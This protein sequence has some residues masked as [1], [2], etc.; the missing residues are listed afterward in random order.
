MYQVIY[1][2][3]KEGYS[4]PDTGWSVGSISTDLNNAVNKVGR[5]QFLQEYL[6]NVQAIFTPENMNKIRALYG[7]SFV[8]ALENILYRMENGGNRRV[9][10][11]KNVTVCTT[12]LMALL[13]LFMFTL[14]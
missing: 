1:L 10:T 14:T 3:V 11:D 13:E 4:K 12:G 9:S 8:D 7:D 5:K 2:K 6:D